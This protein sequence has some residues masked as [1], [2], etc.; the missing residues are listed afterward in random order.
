M[1]LI[2]PL[3]RAWGVPDERILRVHGELPL[4]AATAA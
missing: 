1:R 2:G 4:A 3:V